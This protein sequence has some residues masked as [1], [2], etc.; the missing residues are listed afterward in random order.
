MQYGNGN[1]KLVIFFIC[2]LLVVAGGVGAWKEYQVRQYG[3]V[4]IILNAPDTN[5]VEATLNSQPLTLS[6]HNKVTERLHKGSYTVTITKAGY[7][8]FNDT[9]TVKGMDNLLINATLQRTSIPTFDMSTFPSL[10]SDTAS[11]TVTSSQYFGNHDWL[12]V[13]AIASSGNNVLYV[14]KYDDLSQKWSIQAGPETIVDISEIAAF[15]KDLQQYLQDNNYV[16]GGKYE[17]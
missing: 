16:M 8:T 17:K 5:N 15:P 13:N 14:L 2:L 12:L 9:F 6:N 3:T 11:T 4:G 10:S 7:Q 1:R